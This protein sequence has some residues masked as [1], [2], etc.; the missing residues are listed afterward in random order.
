VPACG[1]LAWPRLISI[2]GPRCARE[3]GCQRQVGP[4]RPIGVSGNT[5]EL[6]VSL[7]ALVGTVA[8]AI[9]TP[10]LSGRVA[11][12]RAD[13]DARQAQRNE[14]KTAIAAFL[15]TAQHLQTQLYAREHDRKHQDVAMMME[16]VW[17]A[18]DQVYILCSP[19]LRSP[20]LQYAQ[21]LN[22]AARHGGADQDWWGN[23]SPRK[24]ALVKAVWEELRLPQFAA[25]TSSP[26]GASS[27]AVSSA[28]DSPG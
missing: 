26:E 20:L 2:S 13:A 10:F 14:I 18:H 12:L 25:S 16:Q 19:A 28:P 1:P 21:A 24:E 7:V 4:R 3:N 17:L 22:D 23:V 11:R 5:T 15:E 6:V 8:T 27:G 9:L